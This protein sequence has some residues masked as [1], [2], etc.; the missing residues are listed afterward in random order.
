MVWLRNNIFHFLL[1]KNMMRIRSNFIKGLL[2]LF[3]S[4]AIDATEFSIQEPNVL[5]PKEK[6]TSDIG[7]IINAYKQ[8]NVDIYKFDTED[9]I[10]VSAYVVSSDEA[11]NFYKTLIIQD[12]PENPMNGLELKVDLRSY[13][14]KYNF[15]RKI[16]LRLSG[17]SI[18]EENGKYV[19]G[20][21][22]G[23]RLIDIPEGLLDHFII[24]TPHT[25]E[26][27][28]TEIT[29]EMVSTRLINT[30]VV[31]EKVQFLKTDIGK[32]FAAEVYD[33]YNGERLIVQ[34][35][36]LAKSFLFTSTYADFSTKP[37]PEGRVRL[38]AVLILDNYS[39]NVTFVLNSPDDIDLLDQDRCDPVYFDCPSK[40]AST[41]KREEVYYESFEWLGNTRDLEKKGWENINVNYGNGRFRKRSRNDNTFLQIL[42]LIHI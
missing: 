35:A 28:P 32:S 30:V 1:Y 27:I 26:I 40:L 9:L 3:S 39:G 31:L 37:L 22:S 17:L 34:C 15:G 42:S 11:G 14:T 16:L 19:V 41:D 29:L 21:L 5:D 8:A 36:N 20:Y 13:Y 18:Q 4:C 12:S 10:I 7:T 33:K 2:I 25:V 38:K 24:R 23:N 6:A